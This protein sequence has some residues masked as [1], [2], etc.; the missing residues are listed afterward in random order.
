MLAI[1]NRLQL[2]IHALSAGWK[3]HELYSV[4]V[5]LWIKTLRPN[6]GMEAVS[7]VKL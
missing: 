5:P 4:V 3:P 6:R 2:L 1:V 7:E